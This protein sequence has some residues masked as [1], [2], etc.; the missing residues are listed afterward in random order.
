MTLQG[1]RELLKAIRPRYL[2]ASKAEKTRILDEFVAVT[3]Y[4]RKYAIQLLRHGRPRR[5]SKKVG[6]RRT[7]GPDV[8]AALVKVWEASG[9]VCGK[10]LQPF[11]AEL[12]DVLEQHGE[13]V[14][15]P[16]TKA[17]LLHMSAASI[18]RHLRAARTRLPQRGR[19]SKPGCGRW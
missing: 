18:D 11:V 8:V 7:Y 14:V 19:P 16:E 6:R 4:N 9:Q 5:S 12:V 2:K 15:S 3:N 13:L 1:K 17:L 10:R